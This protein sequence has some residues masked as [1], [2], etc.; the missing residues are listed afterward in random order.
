MVREDTSS[1]REDTSS[2]SEVRETTSLISGIANM[3]IGFNR[4]EHKKKRWSCKCGCTMRLDGKSGHL[5]SKKHRQK[6]A[7]VKFSQ[8][9][10]A[11][12]ICKCPL[13]GKDTTKANLSTHKKSK[14]CKRSRLVKRSVTK[15]T[16]MESAIGV[17][18]RRG[19]RIGLWG[20]SEKGAV[21]VTKFYRVI[22]CGLCCLVYKWC[23]VPSEGDRCA[24]QKYCN[25]HLV[26][27][28]RSFWELLSCLPQYQP[29]A[30]DTL[31]PIILIKSSCLGLPPGHQERSESLINLIPGSEFS[32]ISN[33]TCVSIHVRNGMFQ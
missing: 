16:N 7:G 22:C 14:K 25:Y 9:K 13:C 10:W 11:T 28:C 19:L 24:E 20:W 5:K 21:C 18:R 23:D 32:A 29:N 6:M 17:K 30:A 33:A 26:T 8:K 31:S 4:K 2:I 1:V 3:S 27:G 12:T 15:W